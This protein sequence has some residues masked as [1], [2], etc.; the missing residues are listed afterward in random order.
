M[1]LLTIVLYSAGIVTFL[2]IILLAVII[3]LRIV[4][5]RRLRREAEFRK[6]TKPLLKSFLS[7]EASVE[8]VRAVL[9]K[10]PRDAVR[11]LLEEADALGE[12]GRKRLPPLFAG[13]SVGQRMMEHLG[14]RSWEK[15]LRAA[16]YLGYLGDD[17]SI[18]GL[19]NA[20]R[21]DLLAVRFAAAESIARL[22]CQAAV[23]PI[24]HSLDIP[25]E[26]S[27]R[28]VAEIIMTLGAHATEPILAILGNPSA[29]P[30]SLAIAARVAG[31]LRIHRAAHPLQILLGHE[32]PNVRL[33]ALRSLASIGEH[34]VVTA[35]AGLAEDPSW[36]VRSGVM[37]ALGRLKAGDHIPLLLQGLS[38][39][40]WWVRINAAE[41]LHALGEPGVSALRDASDHHADAYGRDISRQILQE[42]RILQASPE[43]NS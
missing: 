6:R 14:S 22:G 33:N 23:E 9:E 28:R 7:G 4:T 10:D 24:L 15:R 5:E 19:M 39:P 43:K 38:D 26:V 32:V 36:E 34:S 40:E 1:N 31:S 35:I 2:S 11:I 17:A 42:H 30:N 37:H 8:L 13:M 18:P 41:A 29:N 3:G 20:L 16:E 12:E 21:D 25:G 27:Q